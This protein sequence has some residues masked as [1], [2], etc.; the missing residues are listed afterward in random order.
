MKEHTARWRK[1]VETLAKLL[2]EGKDTEGF[3]IRGKGKEEVWER[4]CE[5]KKKKRRKGGNI[6][7]VSN[8][9]LQNPL[10]PKKGWP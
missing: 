6:M 2:K 5:P 9:H 3:A 8:M 10:T 7:M 1:G 4:R